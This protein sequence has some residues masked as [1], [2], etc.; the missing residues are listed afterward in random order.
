MNLRH[1]EFLRIYCMLFMC[2]VWNAAQ[3][4]VDY[5]YSSL[6]YKVLDLSASGISL[7]SL[8][9]V[10]PL[11]LV[12]D[13]ES[14]EILDSRLF[15]LQYNCLYFDSAQ[16]QQRYP[17][18]RKFGVSYRVTP[19]DFS[20]V[21]ARLD[22]VAIRRKFNSDAIEFDY[23]PYE[24]VKKPWESG[25]L[26]SSGAYTRGL[27][28]GNSQNLVFNSNLNLQLDG[29][30]GNDLEL[31]AALSDNSIPLQPDG[32]TRQL[33]EFDR[34][35]IQLK[36][37]QNTLTAG[38]YD[39]VKPTG[40]FSNYFKRLQG[41][42]FQSSFLQKEDSINVRAAAAVSRGKFS[43]QIIQGQ[44]G[45][46]GPYR[47]QGA[48]GER[49]II[50]L[51]GTEKVYI[52]GQ[53]MQRGLEDD[54]V[55]DYN[56]GEVVFTAHR[57][58]SKDS[59]III[60]F[61]YAVQSYLRSTIAFNTDWNRDKSRFYLNVYSE[62]DSRNSGGAQE[63]S[64]SERKS[65]AAVG[66][67]LLNAYVSG[68]DTLENFDPDRVLYSLVDSVVCGQTVSILVYS[69]NTDSARYAARFTEVTP[70]QGNYVLAQTAANG[71]VFKWSPPDSITCTPSGNFE[72]IIKLI[73][74][75]LKQLWTAGAELKPFKNTDV[76]AELALSNRDLN[77]FSP[78]GNDD[79]LGLA[80]FLHLRQQLDFGKL[81]TDGGKQL[82]RS[83]LNINYEQTAKTFEALNPYRQAEFI[84]DWNVNSQR[85]TVQEQIL[86]SS[87]SIENRKL[88]NLQYEFGAFRRLGIY[89]GNK[90]AAVLSIEKN[91]WELQATGNLLQTDAALEKSIF[92]RPKIDVARTFYKRD[93]T[94]KQA[95]LKTGIYAEREKNARTDIK[96]DTLNSQSFW[97]DLVRIYAEMPDQGRPW[98]LSG[99]VSQR[100]DFAPSESVFQLSTI[101]NELSLNGHWKNR[102]VRKTLNQSVNWVMTLRRLRIINSE[103]TNLEAQRSYLGK[104]DYNLNAWKNA[105]VF[106]LNYELGSGQSPK[107][108]YNYLQVNPGDGQ[109][110]WV[111]RNRD[112]VLQVDE[113]EVAVFQDQANYVRVAVSTPDYV[114]T[115]NV[116]FGPGL[117]IEPRLFW[118]QPENSWQ[119]FVSRLST[120]SNLQ[121]NRRTFVDAV[122]VRPWDPFQLSGLADSALVTLSSGWRNALFI[123]RANPKW[124]AGIVQV[125]NQSRLAIT[126][127]FEQRRN[128]EWSIHFRLNLGQRWSM[129]ADAKKGDK[130][131]DNQTF[132]NRDYQIAS[133]SVGPKIT[134]L[135][136]R[137]FRIN[138]SVLWKESENGIGEMES[139]KQSNWNMELTWNPTSK[140]TAQ[141]FKASTSIRA[142]MT[143]AD[144][145]YLGQ[146]NSAVAFTM[147]EGLQGGKNFLWSLNLDRQLSKS[148]Q[149]GINY[150]GR[151]TG[152][153]RIVHVG[154][155]QVRAL[156]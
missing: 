57:L 25:G 31:R 77:R 86:K 111:D 15:S 108:E 1:P 67:Q 8:T 40:Y 136:S 83:E 60:E 94:G 45:N 50:V 51:A 85:D 135:A 42:M 156:F 124:D 35:F 100:N 21:T 7:D 89:N 154:R 16:V 13:Q 61:E 2:F 30:L 62:Q 76:K 55:V 29:K 151:K 149:L 3:A 33:Q 59:R 122:G 69:T 106:T 141:G 143:F 38:D 65:L 121:I 78:L 46:Q 123:N 155:A 138:G 34:V 103:L 117:R 48:E 9:V 17:D 81:P 47:L 142:S 139:A 5:S 120:Q 110:T 129:E 153:N 99:Y 126:T 137:N 22:T 41:G 118:R 82:W 97:Y 146:A 70:G 39:L 127:G 113:M 20:Q 109:F 90:H 79:N 37:K 19:Y 4:Q 58:I 93:S 140:P 105:L 26:N 145:Q 107:L 147:L 115:N 131:S 73:A 27:S 80:G 36:Q 6:R 11:G 102:A 66:D 74:P 44:E 56:L 114:R 12:M 116:L 52:D 112:S 91:G 134:W 68:I 133:Y 150:E 43:R 71:R 28:F 18:C 98:K 72:P 84:R 75:E 125:D 144:I 88:G 49:F 95:V 92:E 87:V 63:L 96:T 10:P 24:P 132:N 54:Y 130:L 64:E 104:V 101:A 128:K 32:T 23:T 148:V 53:L 119:R 152:T 14:A